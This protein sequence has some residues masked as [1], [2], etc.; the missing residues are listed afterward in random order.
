MRQIITAKLNLKTTPE[1]H[2][3]LRQTQLAYRDARNVKFG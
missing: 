2:H 1:Q 3:L